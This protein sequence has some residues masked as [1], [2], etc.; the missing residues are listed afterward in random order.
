MEQETPKRTLP[1]SLPPVKPPLGLSTQ[2]PTS[3][4]VQ[5]FPPPVCSSKITAMESKLISKDKPFSH[6]G[7]RPRNTP[8]HPGVPSLPTS[9]EIILNKKV[10]NKHK[11]LG[12]PGDCKRGTCQSSSSILT[13][14]PIP[15]KP[16][17]SLPT[18]PPIHVPEFGIEAV[19]ES[20]D[21][22]REGNHQK[23]NPIPRTLTSDR[24]VLALSTGHVHTK[25]AGSATRTMKYDIHR[26]K[27]EFIAESR[28]EDDFCLLCKR[29]VCEPVLTECCG[30]HLCK[31]C[32]MRCN[33]QDNRLLQCP[34]C[35]QHSVLCILDKAK[36]RNIL[37]LK[38]K[39]P[40][41][42][43]GCEWT[44]TIQESREHL[45]RECENVNVNCSW[46]CGRVIE[47]HELLDHLQNS[48]QKRQVVCEYCQAI[49]EVEIITG[50]HVLKCPDYPIACFLGCG[51]KFK[52]TH[53]E[54][55]LAV[56][57]QVVILCPYKFAGCDVTTK[58]NEISEHLKEGIQQHR[59]LQSKH[60]QKELEK[61]S[62]EF[63]QQEEMS[64]KLYKYY[65]ALNKTNAAPSETS[66]KLLLKQL[67]S[68]STHML[69]WRSKEFSQKIMQLKLK[70]RQYYGH[71][72]STA[73]QSISRIPDMMWKVDLKALEI[74]SRIISGQ[75]SEVWK[76]THHKEKQVAIKRH[77][78]GSITSSKFFQEALTLKQFDHVNILK[79]I[80]ACTSEG[81]NLIVTE[82]MIYGSLLDFFKNEERVL[83]SEQQ[84][85]IIEQAASGMAYLEGMK[86]VHRAVSSCSTLIGKNFKC[87]IGSFSLA[88]ILKENDHEYNVPQGE[89]VPMKWSAPEVL[90]QSICS[91]KSDVWS[92]GILQYK[93]ANDL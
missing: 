89:R 22:K 58:R 61:I 27:W 82:L 19:N 78:P 34:S 46:G 63:Q 52:Q 51:G 5:S 28:S 18:L 80:G 37:K 1:L 42:E 60:F 83:T 49:G 48:C 81:E 44:G 77:K 65:G 79:L 39:C 7:E 6:P 67:G 11:G 74:E 17:P 45:N 4:P 26:Y 8:T 24:Q 87:R 92:F 25:R 14:Q 43:R 55:H 36:W 85:N 53:K 86:C 40:L 3:T 62:F 84:I 88:K 76:G 29:I 23:S 68:R 38:V 59:I 70:I 16:S 54:L 20:V 71:I 9:Q 90:M 32:A 50:S 56:C 73:K 75:F 72:E 31:T 13:P 21:F 41:Q 35:M 47:R 30:V 69:D 2:P 15:A 57:S 66:T 12:Y 91:T 33:I 10:V 93:I 64:E